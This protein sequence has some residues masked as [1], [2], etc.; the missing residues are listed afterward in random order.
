MEIVT[1]AKKSCVAFQKP[2][3]LKPGRGRPPE[4]G[5]AVHLKELF[6]SHKEQFQE[7]EVALY[8]KKES[9]RFYCTDLLWGQKRCQELRF[10]LVEMG[11]VQSILAST[12]LTLD[13]RPLSGST[14]IVSGLNVRSGN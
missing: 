10:V 7:A 12:S 2:G 11:S 8:G 1:K 5:P 4:K 6:N 13:P 9:I 3:P 14:I